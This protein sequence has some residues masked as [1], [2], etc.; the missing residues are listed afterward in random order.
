MGLSLE[1]AFRTKPV[2]ALAA[3]ALFASAITCTSAQAQA[4]SGQVLKNHMP[5][6]VRE[7]R[8]L[9]PISGS[10]RMNLTVG[11]PLRN[12]TDLELFLVEVSDPQSSNY[13]QYLSADEFAERFGPAQEDYDKL[14]AFFEASG[15]TVSA[16]HPNRLIL[17]ISGPVAAIEKT[18]HVNMTVWHH[19]RRG[20][21]IAPDQDPSVD[22]GV[23]IADV[24]G[25]DN[26]VLPHPMNL[27]STPLISAP[28][29]VNGSGPSGLFAGGDFRAAYAPGVTLTGAGQS[30]GL[31]ELDGFYT[32]DVAANFKQA[33]LPAVPVSTVLLD[34][35]SGAPGG[36][37]V[38]VILDIVMAG[39][40]APGANIIVYEGT[41]P[42]DV[43]NRMAT[44]NAAKQLSSS[45]GFWPINTTT[46]NI[47][48]QY[49]AQGQSLLQASGDSGAYT[50]GV[51][52]PSDDPNLTVVGGTGLTTTGPGGSWL[53]ET[54]WSGSGGGVSTTYPI[55]SYQQAINMAAL[56]GS[57][58]MRNI[59]DVALTAAIQMFLICNNGQWISVGGTSA[60]APLWAGFIAL[61][62]QQAASKAKPSVGFLNP[63]LYSTGDGANYETA[64]HD[65]TTGSNGFAA[66][67][68]FDLSTGWGTPAGQ[69][70][71]NVLTQVTAT[72]SFSLSTA[73]PT[74]TV[75]AGSN[76]TATVQIA[77][78]SGFSG[79]VSLSATGL[80]TGVTASFSAVNANGASILTLTASSSAGIGSAAI[81]IHGASGTLTANTNLTVAVTG[82]PSFSLKASAATASVTQGG[83]ATDT[84]SITAANGFSGSVTLTASGLPAGVTAAFG[85]SAGGALLTLTASAAAPAATATVTVTGTSGSLNS[86]TQIALTVAPAASFSLT[87]AS[88]TVSVVPGATVTNMITLV[89]KNG[90]ASTVTLAATGLPSGVTASFNPATMSTASTVTFTASS[91]AAAV[92][93]TVTVTATS[94]TVSA[95]V[96]MSVTVKGAPGFTLAA[97]PASV[98]V[99]QGASAASSIAVTLVNGFTGTPTITASGLPTGVTASFSAATAGGRT[100]TFTATSTAPIGVATVTLTGT[101]G[102][103]SASSTIALTVKGVAGF[104]LSAT[105]A[106]VTVSPGTAGSSVIAVNPANGFT[107]PAS[108]S[109][110]GLPTGVTASFDTNTTS[111]SARLTLTASGSAPAGSATVTVT[112]TSG[113]ITAKATVALTVTSA[114]A[115]FKLASTS[116][117]ISVISGGTGTATI[118]IVGQGSFSGPVALTAS[119]LPAGVT[120]SFNPAS[121]TTTSVVTLTASNG[122]VAEAGQ[123]SIK[124]TSGTLTAGLAI[125]VAVVVPQDFTMALAPPSLT[126]ARGSKESTAIAITPVNGFSGTVTLS[127]SGLPAGVTSAFTPLGTSGVYLGMFTATGTATV[128]TA[129]VTITAASGSLTHT[130]ALSLAV[131]A[132]SSGT[133]LVDLSP[134][135]NVSGSA[136]DYLPFTSGGL[137]GGGRSYSGVLLGGSLTFGGT[138]FA[139]GPMGAA[140]VVSSQTVTLPAGKYATLRLLA[141]AVNGKQTG[142]TFT[143]TYTDGTKTTVTQ[144]L[145]DWF[146]PQNYAGESTALPMI[147]RDNSTGTRDGEAFY[148]YGYSLA[149]N[150]AKTV[151]SI[152]LPSNR[153]VI[154][155]AMTLHN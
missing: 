138:V 108:L 139:F 85:P 130:A 33:G 143:V 118:T 91:T 20:Q 62:N 44:D 11:L 124:A 21:F 51:M 94:G 110:S 7:S 59:P 34:G 13:R 147:Y 36:D 150:S 128:G 22:T 16:T 144:S 148:L 153:S 35:F 52:P 127:A 100:M 9:G 17:D 73:A 90:F 69:P 136:V 60:A 70:L 149:L 46:E 26:F 95:S 32:A 155:L 111:T 43:L 87:A 3:V 1:I 24:T 146:A 18:F 48:K 25:L 93:Q 78:Q 37:N 112:G 5:S 77:D 40:M 55:P 75:A 67:P 126:I 89:K 103:A 23:A 28:M 74:A 81:T 97:T 42:N 145:S 8:R 63:A 14:I 58:T 101:S 122:T 121:A 96:P 79:S 31:F 10:T 2:K 135:Y 98:S 12:Q 109:V 104:T 123:L 76:T 141:S 107:G 99:T 154:V 39:Y 30:V 72:P 83:I 117:G 134:S 68:G 120:A 54:T 84:I 19:P 151:S 41:S 57:N 152:A 92:T 106:S 6:A 102:A 66:R 133:A 65:I 140:D 131:I 114:P 116:T 105:P 86:T 71:I 142:Q 61:A 29:T 88:S 15:F 45:W 125:P 47:F 49:I 113:S 27:K 80:P 50:A 137:D 82:A 129:K 4:P 53:S 115:S 64:L 56:G 132:P 38:E 119:G